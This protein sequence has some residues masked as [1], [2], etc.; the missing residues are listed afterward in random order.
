M[1]ATI[2]RILVATDRSQASARAVEWAALMAERYRAD[3]VVLQ[4]VPPARPGSSE[5]EAPD[6]TEHDLALLVE[7]LAGMRGRAKLVVDSD[8]SRAI[9]RAAAEEAVDVV[10]VRKIIDLPTMIEQLSSS[11]RQELDFRNEVQSI[12]RMRSVLA[13]FSRLGVPAV[14][15]DLSTKRLLVME[16]VQGVPVRQAPPGEARAQAAHQLVES[17]YEQLLTEGFFHADPHPGNLMWWNDRIYLLDLGMTGQLAK[18][19]RELLLLLLLACWQEDAPFLAYVMRGLSGKDWPSD[20]DETA[21]KEDLASLISRYRHASLNDLRLGP[22]FH[23][24]T[25]IALRYGIVLPASLA[26]AGKA[27]GQ[28]Q[29]TT[30]WLDPSLDPFAVAGSFLTRRLTR[31]LRTWTINPSS[32]LYHAQKL[33]VRTERL[34][35][36]VERPPAQPRSELHVDSRHSNRLEQTIRNAGRRLG[37]AIT[38]GSAVLATVISAGLGRPWLWLTA[39]VGAIGVGLAAGLVAD[40]VWWRDQ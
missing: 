23:E 35:E 18:E 38:A 7:R 26:L 33:K 29:F 10:V 31:E 24:L 28:M 17:Y 34:M 9:V 36:A 5:P 13:P 3:L 19:V 4:V 30:A 2:N 27:L 22:L 25:Q 14:H 8:P 12:E 21:L 40:I 32:L 6:S 15:A 11:L 1:N 20:L 39:G 37:L 16:E